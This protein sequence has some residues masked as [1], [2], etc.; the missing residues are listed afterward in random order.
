LIFVTVKGCFGWAEED[1][2]LLADDSAAKS[3][4]SYV[5]GAELAAREEILLGT[6]SVP[7]FARCERGCRVSGLVHGL[8]AL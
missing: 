5:H 7:V 6:Q 8:A 4:D 3:G 2:E 1:G